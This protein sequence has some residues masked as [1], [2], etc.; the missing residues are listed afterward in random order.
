MDRLVTAGVNSMYLVLRSNL[1]VWLCALRVTAVTGRVSH[2]AAG[3]WKGAAAPWRATRVSPWSQGGRMAVTAR[4]PR[5]EPTP[6]STARTRSFGSAARS[7]SNANVWG[8]GAS[9][10][11]ALALVYGGAAQLVAGM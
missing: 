3:S 2:G 7:I 10:A 5:P 8:A 11:L 6:G 9:A 1:T 4:A